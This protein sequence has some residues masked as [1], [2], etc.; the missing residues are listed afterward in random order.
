MEEK[1]VSGEGQFWMNQI[2]K[3]RVAFVLIIIAG[4][5]LTIDAIMVLV[6]FIETSPI[7][8]QGDW[9]FDQWTLNYV[10]LFMIFL[11]LWEQCCLLSDVLPQQISILDFVWPI[12]LPAHKSLRPQGRTVCGPPLVEPKN[13][14]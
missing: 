10:V 4:I 12:A 11:V 8:G 13:R 3:H 2:K 7:G 6:W 14:L 1:D 5:V 9:T